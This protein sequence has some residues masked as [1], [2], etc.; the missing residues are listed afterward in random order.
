MGEAWKACR[1]G[2]VWAKPW[3]R[4]SH[5]HKWQKSMPAGQGQRLWG[6]TSG[7]F[8]EQREGQCGCGEVTQ[9]AQQSLARHGRAGFYF[10]AM[11][12]LW[13]VWSR[14]GTWSDWS[15]KMTALVAICRGQAWK[16]GGQSGNYCSR[17]WIPDSWTTAPAP[18][19]CFFLSHKWNPLSL[20]V[21][22]K[23]NRIS[24]K[25]V[26]LAWLLEIFKNANENEQ[27]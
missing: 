16:W 22:T 2:V 26:N 19:V 23:E 13:M 24:K 6:G 17:T 8:E 11:G 3:R 21:I 20:K 1:G 5:A 10:S 4:R 18:G 7:M 27:L 9:V 12:S 14:R 25:R 15:S